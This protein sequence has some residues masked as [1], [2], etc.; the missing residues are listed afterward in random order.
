[1]VHDDVHVTGRVGAIHR[2]F[3]R[4]SNHRSHAL[5]VV[6]QGCGEVRILHPSRQLM[7]RLEMLE[8]FLKKNN[9]TGSVKP[10]DDPCRLSV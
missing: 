8:M 5:V 1:M 4:L 9:I 6:G 2:S 7:N 3:R 10:G